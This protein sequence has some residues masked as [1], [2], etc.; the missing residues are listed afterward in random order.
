[1]LIRIVRMHF[2]EEETE[3]FLEIFNASK[4]KIR[5]FEGCRH[6]ELLQD[7]HNPA[8][9]YTYSHWESEEYL[10][11][12]RDSDLFSEVWTATK[13]LFAEKPLAYSVQNIMTID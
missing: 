10:N 12:Y 11:G 3:Q 5:H 2:R 4:Q 8:V 7:V 9:F 6:L 13:A 1:M